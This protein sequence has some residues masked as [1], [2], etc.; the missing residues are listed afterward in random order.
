MADQSSLKV[1]A[2]NLAKKTFAYKRLAQSRSR[3][4]V[5]FSGFMPGYSNPVVRADNCAQ[6]V[7]GIK[8]A[9]NISKNHTR[10]NRR[11]FE[12]ICET[13]LKLK[14]KKCFC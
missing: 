5:A 14:L 2:A 12:W 9:A 1:R 3:S 7:T 11:I 6:Y 10:K 13:G 4:A 8:I